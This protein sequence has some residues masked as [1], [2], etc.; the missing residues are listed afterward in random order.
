MARK[1]NFVKTKYKNIVSLDDT[2]G[3]TNYYANFMLDGISYQKKNLTKLFNATTAKQAS[4]VLEQVKS[5]LRQN[6]NPFKGSNE[7]KVKNIVLKSINDREPVGKFSEYKMRLERFYY[8]YIDPVIGHLFLDK[9]SDE[10]IRTIMKSLEGYRKEYKQNLQILMFRIFE[11]E[12]RKGNI[13]HNPFYELDYGKHSNKEDFDIRLNEPME[14]AAIK[15]YQTAFEYN[16]K[17]RLFLLMTIMMA[18]RVGEIHKL[19][20]GNIKRYSDGSWYILATKDITKTNVN[21]KYPLPSEVVNLLPKEVLNQEYENEKLF[22]FSESSITFNWN[23]FVKQAKININK[24]Y[25]LTSHDCRKLFLSILTAKGVDSDL[26][27]R[28]ISH[29]KRGMKGVYLDVSYRIRKE[30]FENW[31]D[32]LRN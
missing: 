2:G 6:K 1:N 12:L 19:K 3:R 5:E 29:K 17:Y 11:L 4:D 28:C 32:F 25:S 7:G 22:S 16:P 21:E 14:D 27:D 8:N 18:R 31:W 13:R 24:G 10:H 9:V 23:L 26:A 30:I 15:L 20:A